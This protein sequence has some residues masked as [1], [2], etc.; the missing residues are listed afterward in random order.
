[1]IRRDVVRRR[2]VAAFL[3]LVCATVAA[4]AGAVLVVRGWEWL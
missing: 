2:P 1:M 3:A 4:L